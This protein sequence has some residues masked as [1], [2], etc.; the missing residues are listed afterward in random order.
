MLFA[1]GLAGLE[2]L[3]GSALLGG[4]VE[5]LNIELGAGS[6]DGLG[7]IDSQGRAESMVTVSDVELNIKMSA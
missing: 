1:D 7:Q 2:K 4:S 5:D 3:D 6:N